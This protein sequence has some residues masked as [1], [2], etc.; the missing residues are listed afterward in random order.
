MASPAN[1]AFPTS[2]PRRLHVAPTRFSATRSPGGHDEEPESPSDQRPDVGVLAA[3]EPTFQPRPR[4]PLCH[5]G[6][7]DDGPAPPGGGGGTPGHPVSQ[8]RSWSQVA[9]Q[10]RWRGAVHL[11]EVLHDHDAVQAS[12]QAVCPG[13]VVARGTVPWSRTIPASTS[14]SIPR[15]AVTRS[16][17]ACNSDRISSSSSAREGAM[18]SGGG[19]S[20]SSWRAAR[21][22]HLDGVGVRRLL[23]RPYQGSLRRRGGRGRLPG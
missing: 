20:V 17:V 11:Q 3:R 14:T 22:V 6:H 1:P 19:G 7:Q 10:R 4:S 9:F 23:N 16:K 18:S 21:R 13:R 12:G 15:S 5:H 2:A 8:F